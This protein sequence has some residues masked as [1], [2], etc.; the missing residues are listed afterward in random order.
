MPTSQ[1]PPPARNISSDLWASSSSSSSS[2]SSDQYT[3]DSD[4]LPGPASRPNQA[5]SKLTRAPLRSSRRY[6]IDRT[7][8]YLKKSRACLRHALLCV[9][10]IGRLD[11][12]RE[13]KGSLSKRS[14]TVHRPWTELSDCTVQLQN[15]IRDSRVL[16]NEQLVKC[17]DIFLASYSIHVSPSAHDR[18]YIRDRLTKAEARAVPG[19]Q[20][21]LE[22]LQAKAS[23]SELSSHHVE[24]LAQ[25]PPG[26]LLTL[27]DCA[28][29][30][31]AEGAEILVFSGIPGSQ[32]EDLDLMDRRMLHLFHIFG[33]DPTQ[34][35]EVRLQDCGAARLPTWI[36]GM[37][38][39]S[40]LRLERTFLKGLPM[41][42]LEM[43]KLRWISSGCVFPSS[44][45]T[46]KGTMASFKR[47]CQIPRDLYV[48]VVT[49]VP[50]IRGPM[51]LAKMSTIS[52]LRQYEDDLDF[53]AVARA[54]PPKFSAALLESWHCERCD[55]I[56][57]DDECG[58]LSCQL[59]VKA[60]DNSEDRGIWIK[61]RL[62]RLC[63]ATLIGQAHHENL[64]VK[65]GIIVT[66]R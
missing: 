34:I 7:P 16:R 43:E 4:V 23:K 5:A 64:L 51:S 1:H 6:S 39:L 8:R 56:C 65:L 17:L 36:R 13:L 20:R 52:A 37:A 44:S 66:S 30:R 21:H 32:L 45:I 12:Q 50:N 60:F 29:P 24:I 9:W 10:T 33:I 3:S 48:P 42:I 28:L 11:Q 49:N 54:L 15:H 31:D 46:L 63:R 59:L 19:T 62:C 58:M 53:W 27:V 38:N 25:C 35:D 26:I 14:T 22:E 47:V 55:K 2:S 40:T 41:W 57:L 61:S 18:S